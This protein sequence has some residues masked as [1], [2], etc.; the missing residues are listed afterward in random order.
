VKTGKLFAFEDND[1][2]P[3]PREQSRGSA[4]SRSSTNDGDIVRVDLH[5]AF[6]LTKF[7]LKRKSIEER[8]SFRRG[9]RKSEPDW[10]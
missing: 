9:R 5:V 1:A 2:P 6:I 10:R 4:A 8:S 7:S 3:G